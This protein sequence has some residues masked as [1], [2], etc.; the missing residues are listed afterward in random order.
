MSTDRLV[1][2][3]IILQKLNKVNL[4]FLL[5]IFF[6]VTIVLL[7]VFLIKEHRETKKRDEVSKKDKKVMEMS[8]KIESGEMKLSDF[9]HQHI[10]DSSDFA[11][12]YSEDKLPSHNLYYV[13]QKADEKISRFLKEERNFLS[14]WSAKYGFDIIFMDDQDKL[15]CNMCY[16]QDKKYLKHGF[17]R[18]TNTMV[19]AKGT[20][21]LIDK[22]NYYEITGDSDKEIKE[23]FEDIAQRAYSDAI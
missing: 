17:L 11:F 5:V 6:P 4:V 19:C 21:V 22:Y 14:E 18:D 16:P 7:I 23:C 15:L 13:E 1:N 3:E 20:Y 8:R 2:I 12:N 9:P 10:E